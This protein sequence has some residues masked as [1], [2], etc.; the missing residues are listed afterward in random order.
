MI[1]LIVLHEFLLHMKKIIISFHFILLGFALHGQFNIIEINKQVKEFPDIYDLSTPLNAGV[2][3]IYFMINGTDNLW[4]DA[5][6]KRYP[7]RVKKD[8]IPNR[9]VEETVKERLLNDTVKELILY[10]DSV[11]RLIIKR[12]NSTNYRIRDFIFENGRWLNYGENGGGLSLEGW[13]EDFY[14]MAP[15]FPNRLR[16]LLDL[17]SI[18]TDTLAFF[19]YVKQ[20]GAEPKAFLLEVL[21]SYPLVIYGEIHRRK[22]SWD[23]LSNVL[24]DPNFPEIVGTV[25]LEMPAYQQSE[26]DRFYASQELD[27]EILLDIMRSFLPT[28]WW[29]RGEYE[30]LVNIWNLNKTLSADKQIRVV[31]TDEQT[32]WKL[33]N[34]P[35]D[36]EKI[37]KNLIDR[38]THMADVVEQVMK[39]K[40]DTRNSL[41]VTGFGHARKSL[42]PGGYSSAVDQ[43]PT[44]TAGAQLVQRLSDKNVFAVLQHVPMTKNVGSD[45]GL[46]RQG[47]YDVVFEMTGN[48]PVAFR[49]AGTPFGS[50]PFDADFD[51]AFNSKS[52]NYEDN[53]DGYIFLQSL[54]EE[55]TDYILYDIA[56]D[57]FVKEINRRKELTGWNLY[58]WIEGELTKEKI[59]EV[60]KKDE[61]KKRWGYLFE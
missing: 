30:F 11:A 58:G 2:T 27:T 61:G 14:T 44:L 40:T 23:L 5:S 46:V 57:K 52:G 28:G 16:R 31:P 45:P 51:N 17:R 54:K 10:K 9:I 53:F 6:V 4:D 8:T 59:I 38:N 18:S 56:S 48:K 35:E 32:P 20:E 3:C 15:D 7:E 47:L 1:F 13:R 12:S 19:N 22:V 36:F 43:E 33:L 55:E 50:E 49:L 37:E 60:F 42:V 24:H 39:T 25:F 29:D 41:F 21:A 26:F 34:T